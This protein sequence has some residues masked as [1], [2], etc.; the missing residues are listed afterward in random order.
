M[1]PVAEERPQRT[2]LGVATI[3]ITVFAMAFGDALVKAVSADFSL[4]QIYVL[5]SAFAIPLLVLLVRG[6]VRARAPGWIALRSLFLMLMWLAFYGALPLIDLAVVAAAYYSGPLFITLLSA[7][8]I[9]E[10]VGPRR[11]C[12]V[13]LGFGGVLVILRPDGDAFSPVALLPVLSGLFYALAAVVTR[14]KC[15]QEKPLVLSLWLNLGFL[16]FGLLGS[17]AVALL[18]PD[19][20][21][22]FFL[23]PWTAMDA[24]DWAVIAG[25]GLL[26]VFIGAGTAKAYQ[27]GPPAVIAAFDYAYLPFAV[28]WGALLFAERPDALT[29]LGMALIAGGGLLSLWARPPESRP[30]RPRPSRPA[31]RPWRRRSPPPAWP[32]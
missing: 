2:G 1:A 9:G 6:A 14:A 15:H 23:G 11:W 20:A 4:W 10:P 18:A 3:L 26:I 25:L 24:R 13:L 7:L 32:S 17:A 5:R 12:A 27:C 16:L 31:L 19:P 30:D 22:P 28:A 8:L 21:A 29:L